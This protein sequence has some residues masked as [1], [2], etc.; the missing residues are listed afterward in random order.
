M[1]VVKRSIGRLVARLFGA[2]LLAIAALTV[3]GHLALG[4]GK[5]GEAFAM[6]VVVLGLPSFLA[7]SVVLWLAR[8]RST[9]DSPSD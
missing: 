3:W 2:V 9:D 7:G 4:N 5:G 8:G 6:L 1:A